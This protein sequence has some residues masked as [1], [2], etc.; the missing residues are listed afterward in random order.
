[1]HLQKELF[2]LSETTVAVRDFPS[3]EQES[4]ADSI[5]KVIDH[6]F[7]QVLPFVEETIEKWN[8]RTQMIKN[9]NSSSQ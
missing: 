1:M 3:D 2:K 4:T 8:S 6:N 5:Y 9:L 7:S